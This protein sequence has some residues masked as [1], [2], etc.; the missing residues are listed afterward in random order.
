MTHWTI[1]LEREGAAIVVRGEG[2]D[3]H[4]PDRS[5]PGDPWRLISP[6]CWRRRISGR[7]DRST[8]PVHS[9]GLPGIMHFSSLTTISVPVLVACLYI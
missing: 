2:D 1:T 9:P 8:T 7:G 4:A 5:D 6:Y 3:L